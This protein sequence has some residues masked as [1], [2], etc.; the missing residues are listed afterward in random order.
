MIAASFG[1]LRVVCAYFVN[2]EAVDSGQYAYKLTWLGK[3]ERYLADS[4]ARWPQ[5]ALLGISTSPRTTATC[6]TRPAGPADAVLRARARGVSAPAAMGL[7]DS[8]RHFHADGGQYSWWDYRAAM[9]RRNL[10][11]RIDHI[12]LSPPLLAR[13]HNPANRPRPTQKRTAIRPHASGGRLGWAR[14]AMPW[15]PRHTIFIVQFKFSRMKAWINL[16]RP[17]CLNRC[18]LR[19][20]PGCIACWCAMAW[21]AWWRAPLPPNWIFRPP[22]CR[23]T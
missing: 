20:A 9:F 8:Y 5:L 11:L 7:A 23:F 21:M 6:T 13:A 14:G 22:I 10:G 18:Q 12:L 19:R 16:L 2:G 15:A 4:L 3:L 1:E 17:N